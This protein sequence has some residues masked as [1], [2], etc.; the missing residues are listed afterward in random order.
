[1]QVKVKYLVS[2][3]TTKL[4]LKKRLIGKTIRTIFSM[5]AIF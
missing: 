2:R 5:E 1:M 4:K 3:I